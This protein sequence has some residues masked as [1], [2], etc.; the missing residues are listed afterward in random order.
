MCPYLF[1]H[2]STLL[3]HLKFSRFL[4]M[5]KDRIGV[6]GCI[7]VHFELSDH[8]DTKTPKKVV[9]MSK[10]SKFVWDTQLWGFT[11]Q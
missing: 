1:S 9:K 10:K 2:T 7:E 3:L 8:N 11:A 4:Y 5:K 6:E